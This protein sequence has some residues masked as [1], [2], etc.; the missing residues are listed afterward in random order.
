VFGATSSTPSDAELGCR[1]LGALAALVWIL[2]VKV[3]EYAG[4]V[5]IIFTFLANVSTWAFSAAVLTL[6]WDLCR[7][8]TVFGRHWR[9]TSCL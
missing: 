9:W 6:F 4:L 8:G 2:G 5:V 3:V 7:D 1:R